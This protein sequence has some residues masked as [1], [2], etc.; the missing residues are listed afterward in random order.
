MNATRR[1]SPRSVL[2]CGSPLPLFGD[3]SIDARDSRRLDSAFSLI[4]VMVAVFILAV[5]LVGM[6]GG[7]GTALVSSKEAETYTQA[8]QLAVARAE[9]LRADDLFADGETTGTEG[10]LKWRQTIAAANVNGLHDVEIVVQPA[11]G[12]TTLY[13]LR[14]LLYQTPVDRQTEKDKAKDKDRSRRRSSKRQ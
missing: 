12:D 7:I 2:E 4:E 14:T 3:P 5:A 13:S 6:V 1:K 11:T 9:F 8:V 10:N